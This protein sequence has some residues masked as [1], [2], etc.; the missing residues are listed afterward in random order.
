MLFFRNF[1]K[2]SAIRKTKSVERELGCVFINFIIIYEKVMLKFNNCKIL[3]IQGILFKI[4]ITFTSSSG[5]TQNRPLL[6]EKRGKN[7]I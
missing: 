1:R 5:I 7:L 4:K 3:N 6:H 2:L